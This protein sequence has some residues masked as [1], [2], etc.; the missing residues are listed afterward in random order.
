MS[1]LT[2]EK[3]QVVQD[4]VLRSR[5]REII[6]EPAPVSRFERWSKH[7]LLTLF[8][9]FGLTWGVGTLLTNHINEEREE[10][11]RAVQE[12]RA[13]IE[14]KLNALRDYARLIYGRQTQASMLRA[15][16][17]RDA[18]DAEL[19]ERK[20]EYDDA[21]SRWGG[22]LQSNL[23][24]IRGA[25][26]DEPRYSPFEAEVEGRLERMYRQ[27]DSLLNRAYY[28][29]IQ[30]LPV[31]DMA[32][33]EQLLKLADDCGSAILDQLYAILFEQRERVDDDVGGGN[34]V[35][36]QPTE[37]LRIV[38]QACQQISR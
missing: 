7:P 19:Q 31:G 11:E 8:V 18:P 15:A 5:V 38:Q 17:A 29:R 12:E 14:S 13:R 35:L 36:G 2:P 33:E 25:T 21:T 27:V 4:E 10:R 1:N 34:I 32:R 30:G 6:G 3:E 37:P 28:R 9:G 23:F 24:L 20:R 22:E 26:T 16:I